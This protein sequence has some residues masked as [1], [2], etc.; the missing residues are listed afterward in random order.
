TITDINGSYKFYNLP[1]GTYNLTTS[2][3]KTAGGWNPMN[4]LLINR[5]YIGAYYFTESQKKAGDV[6]KSGNINPVDALIVN[7][8][9][10]ELL[11]SFKSGDWMFYTEPIIVSSADV[12]YN[13]S[14]YCYGDVSGV[15]NSNINYTGSDA[16]ISSASIT[17]KAGDL[18]TI[19]I[20]VKNFNNVACIGFKIQFD[21]NVLKDSSFTIANVNSNITGFLS[22]LKNNTMYF[23]WHSGTATGISISEG[24]LFDIKIKYLGGSTALTFQPEIILGSNDYKYLSVNSVNGTVSGGQVPVI[25]QQPANKTKCIRDSVLFKVI[26]TGATAYKWQKNGNDITGATNSNFIISSVL[27]ADEGIY[28]CLISN[29]YGTVSSNE[30][31][32]TVKSEPV[33]NIIPITITKNIGESLNLTVSPSGSAPFLYQW[34]KNQVEISAATNN[35]FD[36][37]HIK[38]NDAGS[39]SCKVKNDCGELT[40]TL[41]NLTVNVANAAT[42]SL[43]SVQ[44]VQGQEIII[45]VTAKNINMLGAL[46]IAVQ[47]DVNVLD[48][49]STDNLNGIFGSSISINNV[50]GK[51]LYAWVNYAGTTI[52]L[53]DA[54]LFTIKYL[55]K[56]GTSNINFGLETEVTDVVGENIETVLN[57]GKVTPAN[58]KIFIVEHPLSSIKC[59]ND[60]M[61]FK[62]NAESNY[63]L[64]YKWMKNDNII[65]GAT[66]KELKLYNLKASDAGK[67]KCRISNDSLSLLTNEAV[68]TMNVL[69]TAKTTPEGNFIICEG[70]EL[71]V[72]SVFTGAGLTYQWYRNDLIIQGASVSTYNI[73]DA[74]SYS[75]KVSNTN[76][77]AISNKIIVDTKKLPEIT[78]V[79]NAARC[80]EGS[81]TLK[82]IPSSGNV[83][84]YI[85][86]NLNTPVATGNE[87]KTPIINQ[88]T[89][90]LVEAIDGDCKSLLKKDVIASINPLPD[91]TFIYDGS[92]QLCEGQSLSLKAVYNQSYSYQWQ[93]NNNNIEGAT[94]STYSATVSGYYSI[95]VSNTNNCK[96]VSSPLHFNFYSLPVINLPKDTTITNKQYLS[97][98]AGAGF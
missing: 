9:Y 95:F 25:T 39:Y 66:N 80:G 83:N 77:F 64:S 18:I 14:A 68:L 27:S 10:V 16:I 90:Y 52:N 96:T 85:S 79:T 53:P 12:V 8:R 5:Y 55:Y 70:S 29:T 49:V 88:N 37:L 41:A 48:Y 4:A 84:W 97:I 63:I 76:C 98:D 71:L 62:A 15:F 59:E 86:S 56:G 89:I 42:L 51:T 13:Y 54:T 67:Y 81:V 34:F 73:K 94:L 47:Y 36:I 30:A 57:N 60:S 44:A 82:A 32:L 20:T 38:A 78:T 43:S 22:N 11:S 33:L 50:S 69:P 23:A 40:K 26:A 91:S 92:T 61:I 2:T 3:N 24:K 75:L 17:A 87:F 45:P 21:K 28:R 6:N 46:G 19:P 93:L 65:E 7:R 74:G 35:S 31:T 1:N 72:S 58:H